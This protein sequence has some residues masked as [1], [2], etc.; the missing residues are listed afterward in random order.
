MDRP[1]SLTG[2]EAGARCSGGWI[3]PDGAFYPAAY[4]KHLRVASELRSTGSGPKDA[5]NVDD[6]WLLVKCHG[7]V[8]FSIYLTQAQMDTVGDMLLATPA[9]GYRSQLLAS[10]R[11]LRELE[12]QPVRRVVSG[13]GPSMS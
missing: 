8:L 5:W 13:T 6:P 9:S 3:A 10:I 12:E 2:T 4:N 11:G 1:R 7:E